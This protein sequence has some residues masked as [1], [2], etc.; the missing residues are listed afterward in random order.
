MVDADDIGEPAE[1]LAE[2]DRDEEQAAADEQAEQ[3]DRV[4]DIDLDHE[5][6]PAAPAALDEGTGL[7]RADIVA[8][9]RGGRR[10][11]PVADRV[12]GAAGLGEVEPVVAGGE[13]ERQVV[14]LRTALAML[15]DP[16]P[17]RDRHA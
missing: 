7:G 2:D 15:P 11:A 10:S 8:V 6:P 5:H 1:E 9:A 16:L 13:P 4:A 3:E 17:G 14:A 12:E